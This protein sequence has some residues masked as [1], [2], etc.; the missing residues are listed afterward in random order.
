MVLQSNQFYQTVIKFLLCEMGLFT[1]HNCC[2][3][4]LLNFL[5]LKLVSQS[6]LTIPE[7]SGYHCTKFTRYF[8]APNVTLLPK[9]LGIYV[10]LETRL[11][12]IKML[13]NRKKL[14]KSTTTKIIKPKRIPFIILKFSLSKILDAERKILVFNNVQLSE[15]NIFKD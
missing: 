9:C 15:E 14:T 2:V 10:G 5:K 6:R 7:F 11:F 13:Q 1:M 4:W 8:Q 3:S 12:F